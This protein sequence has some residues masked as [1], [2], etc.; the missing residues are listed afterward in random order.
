MYRLNFDRAKAD[1]ANNTGPEV[2]RRDAP[3]QVSNWDNVCAVN[4]AENVQDSPKDFAENCP[5]ND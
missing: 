2:P 3:A 1:R 4:E 5:Y